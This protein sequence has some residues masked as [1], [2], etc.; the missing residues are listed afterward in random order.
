MRLSQLRSVSTLVAFK[1][2]FRQQD[3]GNGVS[4]FASKTRRFGAEQCVFD[5]EYL[6]VDHETCLQHSFGELDPHDALYATAH[7][8]SL[9]DGVPASCGAVR[10]LFT[11][12]GKN[13]R[14]AVG[15]PLPSIA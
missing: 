14:Q 10:L 13:K 8:F 2:E 6:L 11:T 4:R 1:G 15:M 12:S 7:R 9:N 5:R 3:L